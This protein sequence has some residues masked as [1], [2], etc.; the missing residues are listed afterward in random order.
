M[1][2]HRIYQQKV[3][4]LFKHAED[5][6]FGSKVNP[7]TGGRWVPGLDSI[8]RQKMLAER[9]LAARDA[10]AVDGPPDA[11]PLPVVADAEADDCAPL[12]RPDPLHR[13]PLRPV[14][15]RLGL[16][17]RQATKLARV[18]LWRVGI[19]LPPTGLRARPGRVHPPVSAS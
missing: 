5:G 16:R 14:D 19:A 18:C 11:Q 4:W 7:V 9:A 17:L 13:I 12:P 10:F 3:D 8:R 1:R 2:S 15:S 6:G